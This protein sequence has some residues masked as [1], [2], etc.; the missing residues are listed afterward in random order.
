[1]TWLTFFGGSG[2]DRPTALVRDSAPGRSMWRID[3]V[4]ELPTTAGTIEPSAPAR[5]RASW[6]RSLR[7][8]CRSG[9]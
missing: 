4:A 2:D 8:E 5:K 6:R 7:T 3:L 9:S 1:V